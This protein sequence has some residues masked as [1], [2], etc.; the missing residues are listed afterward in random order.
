[1]TVGLKKLSVRTSVATGGLLI[2]MSYLLSA[3]TTDIR[4]FYI[5]QGFV[6]GE[7]REVV[8]CFDVWCI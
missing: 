5:L 4:I 6:H 1:M 3:F 2:A 7:F 8:Q